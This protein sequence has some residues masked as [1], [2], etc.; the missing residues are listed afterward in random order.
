M[1]EEM[2]GT[3]GDKTTIEQGEPARG[4]EFPTEV[5]GDEGASTGE[6]AAGDDDD[7]VV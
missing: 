4:D 2:P 7:E 5:E 1:S 6:Q 3:E